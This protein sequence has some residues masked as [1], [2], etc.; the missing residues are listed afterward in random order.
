MA[1]RSSVHVSTYVDA[2]EVLDQISTDDLVAE[3]K[4]RAKAENGK[5]AMPENYRDTLEEAREA[6]LSK[7]PLDVLA[8]IERI[9][10]VKQEDKT[11][12]YMRALAARDPV[13]KYP[14]IQ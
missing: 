10:Y 2:D 13:T 3:L 14:V 5:M 1:R 9:L 8:L 11:D 6:L 4:S 7:R 12:K